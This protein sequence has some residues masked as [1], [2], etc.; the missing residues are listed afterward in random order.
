MGKGRKTMQSRPAWSEKGCLGP[1]Q[2]GS[3]NVHPG[4]ESPALPC[5]ARRREKTEDYPEP[6][7][8]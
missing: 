2:V 4:W 3:L 6:L 5:P 7:E 8:V 1:L